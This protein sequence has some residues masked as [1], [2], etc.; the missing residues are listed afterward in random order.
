MKNTNRGL[1]FSRI[2]KA[3]TDICGICTREHSCESWCGGVNF[4][5][6]VFSSLIRA[7]RLRIFKLIDK[8][9]GDKQDG[10]DK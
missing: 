4:H 8:L 6:G 3:K 9:Q 2:S 1:D 5:R 7:L 10:G